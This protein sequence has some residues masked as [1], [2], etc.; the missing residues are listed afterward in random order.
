[1][2]FSKKGNEMV[3]FLGLRSRVVNILVSVPYLLAVNGCSQPLSIIQ[4][5]NVSRAGQEARADFVIDK[6]GNYLLS[7]YFVIGKGDKYHTLDAIERRW[8]IWGGCDATGVVI[9]VSF[10]IIKDGGLLSSEKI[11]TTGVCWWGS[12]E[13]AGVRKSVG[14]RP[15]YYASLKP[16]NYSVKVKTL[17]DVPEFYGVESYAEFS[18]YDPKI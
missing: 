16:G 2:I 13:Y 5:L 6:H 15:V 3:S 12:F 4:P 18:Y 14:I 7:I 8:E 11:L 9:P 10:E 1:M 17:T